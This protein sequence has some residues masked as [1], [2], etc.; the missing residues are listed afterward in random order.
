[1]SNLSDLHG[2]FSNSLRWNAET[3]VLGTAVFNAEAGERELQEI[4]LGNAAT[5]VMDLATRER[6]Y[7]LIKVGTYDMRLTPVG[8]PAP[9]RPDDP[10]YK[11]ALGC[12]VWNPT[13]G[14]LR[15]EVCSTLFRDVIANVWDRARFAPEAIRG[16]QPVIR[17]VDRVEVPIK[18]V[19]K[20]FFVPVAQIVGWVERNH[21]PGW[22][23]R[24]PTVAPPTAPPLLAAASPAPSTP[25][26]KKPAKVGKGAVKPAPDDP[27]DDILGGDSIPWA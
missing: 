7:G 14:D 17:F 9:P 10:E 8:S 15:L 5:F 24:T 25:A 6:G 26:A 27:I 2:I 12:S 11:P 1:M 19:G 16:L 13:F 18:S 22:A 3:G 23:N 20:T 21:V 4:A